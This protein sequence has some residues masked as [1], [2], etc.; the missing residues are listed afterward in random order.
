[1]SSLVMSSAGAYVCASSASCAAPVAVHVPAR[2]DMMGSN[3][4]DAA[5]QGRR[6]MQAF[7]VSSPAGVNQ[8]VSRNSAATRAVAVGG[9]HGVLRSYVQTLLQ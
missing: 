6:D 9:E 2:S 5:T 7:M 3:L 4:I 8:D 1:M